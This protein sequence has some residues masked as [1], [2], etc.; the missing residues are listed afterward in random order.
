MRT[1]PTNTKTRQVN[2]LQNARQEGVKKTEK[3]P[4]KQKKKVLI[5]SPRSNL[6]FPQRIYCRGMSSYYEIILELE[7]GL[8]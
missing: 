7:F 4:K 3:N 5:H 2:K 1:G 6:N 8:G